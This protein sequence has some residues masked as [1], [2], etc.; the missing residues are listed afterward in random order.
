M[1]PLLCPI[2][3]FDIITKTISNQ[4]KNHIIIH[5]RGLNKEVFVDLVF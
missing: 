4:K 3:M 2:A 1:T 5:D